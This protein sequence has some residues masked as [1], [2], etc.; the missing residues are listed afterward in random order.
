[1]QPW[2]F[3]PQKVVSVIVVVSFLLIFHL[4][5]D[6]INVLQSSTFVAIKTK[7]DNA[8][9]G[10]NLT[11]VT[12]GF[13]HV[14]KSS[15]STLTGVIRNSCHSFMRHRKTGQCRNEDPAIPNETV[16]SELVTA[17]YHGTYTKQQL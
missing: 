17:Y 13:I 5:T 4:S 15:G 2:R 6:T 3:C 14:G 1:M 11:N 12:A 16:A 10:F 9:I 7:P 8:T